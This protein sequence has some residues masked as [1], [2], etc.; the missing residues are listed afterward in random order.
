VASSARPDSDQGWSAP[1]STAAFLPS[2]AGFD[3][4]PRACDA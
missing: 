3:D 4:W 1:L 2:T